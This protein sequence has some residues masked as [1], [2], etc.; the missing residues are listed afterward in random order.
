MKSMRSGQ[1]FIL[2]ID[3][4]EEVISSI[5]SAAEREGLRAAIIASFIGAMR[6]CR[7]IL[8]KGV[9]KSIEGHVE[10]VGNGNIT[11]MGGSPF[12]HLHVSC[13]SDRGVW[14]GHLIEGRAEIFCET[15]LY[16]LED[17]VERVYDK[18]LAEIGV[19]VPFRL[20]IGDG[21]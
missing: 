18:G 6:E 16:V 8:R 1:F 17:P 19:T 3:E 11:R 2:R 13:G 4:G 5:A 12:V 21:K 14:V 7:L 15:A 10:A 9:E 20:D